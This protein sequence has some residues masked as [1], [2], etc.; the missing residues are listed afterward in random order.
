MFLDNINTLFIESGVV[1][2]HI[3]NLIVLAILILLFFTARRT[4]KSWTK[5]NDYLGV[6]TKTINSVRYG[7]L[8]KKIEN[9][10]LPNSEPLVESLNR[11]IETLYDREKMIDEYQNELH[12]QNKFLEAVIDSLSDG[13]IVYDENL[14]I[15]RA[16]QKISDW[17]D[18]D[19]RKLVGAFLSDHIVLPLN[20]KVMSL[21]EDDIYLLNDKSSNFIA[22]SM[23]LKLEW[24]IV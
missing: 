21:Q 20:K 7:D 18:I 3:L 15:L 13:L 17:F 24:N 16:T 4:G 6:I 19:G 23:E 9:V 8:T 1:Y 12:R 2:I 5:I 14:K 22:T 11:M 10:D